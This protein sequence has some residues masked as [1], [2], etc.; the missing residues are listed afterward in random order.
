MSDDNSAETTPRVRS[1]LNPLLQAAQKDV[2]S[3]EQKKQNQEAL[4]QWLNAKYLEGR[5]SGAQEG[6]VLGIVSTLSVVTI[7]YLGYLGYQ[8]LIVPYFAPAAKEVV[9]KAS[10]HAKLAADVAV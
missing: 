10:R 7:A 2:A 5:D 1:S 6:L 9:K 8:N 4:A 3:D